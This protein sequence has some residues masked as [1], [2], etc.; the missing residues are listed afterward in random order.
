[1]RIDRG[2]V[3]IL[4]IQAFSRHVSR[5]WLEVSRC[6][7]RLQPLQ[8]IHEQFSSHHAR[9]APGIEAACDGRLWV[10]G[11]SRQAEIRGAIASLRADRD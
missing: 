1:M 3:E 8:A 4:L 2:E 6:G 10:D 9:Y 5:L 7:L 11:L